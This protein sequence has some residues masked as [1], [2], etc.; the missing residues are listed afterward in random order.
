MAHALNDLAAHL[1]ALAE[2]LGVPRNVLCAGEKPETLAVQRALEVPEGSALAGALASRIAAAG[3]QKPGAS[4]PLGRIL[5]EHPDLGGSSAPHEVLGRLLTVLAALAGDSQIRFLDDGDRILLEATP[6][7]ATDAVQELLA[8][9]ASLKLSIN[10]AK[11][12]LLTRLAPADDAVVRYFVCPEKAAARL[13][14]PLMEIEGDFPDDGRKLVLLV[15]DDDVALDGDHLAVVGG[16][17]LDDWG[18]CS[19]RRPPAEAAGGA[20]GEEAQDERRVRP[21]EMAEDAVENVNW[22]DLHFERLTPLH[23]SVAPSAEGYACES[24]A[25]ARAL[26]ARLL[27]LC[28]AYSANQTRRTRESAKEKADD[29]TATFGRDD[30]LARV[31]FGTAAAGVGLPEEFLAGVARVVDMVVWAYGGRRK[32]KDRLHAFQNVVARNLRGKPET[33]TYAALVGLAEDVEREMSWFWATYWEGKLGAYFDRVA[34]VMQFVDEVRQT[35]EDQVQRLTKSLADSVLA[36]VAVVV[37]TFIAAM[38]QSPFNATLFRIGILLYVAYLFFFPGLLGL[39]SA[40]TQFRDA[41][42]TFA[43]RKKL[44]RAHLYEK[45]VATLLKPVEDGEDRFCF[46][47]ALTALIYV[48]VCCFL[49]LGAL[50]GP[51]LI[52]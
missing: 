28:L 47:F 14:R 34:Q 22:I 5:A 7:L 23:L 16:R 13:S 6:G 29:W 43:E 38:F 39:T 10:L 18:Q 42:A 19:A 25:I 33:E 41:K 40:W 31:R 4:T 1:F 46:W 26:Y 49:L 11:K 21:H 37:G 15:A 45:S 2:L 24:C 27:D 36:G 12:A 8:G 35:Y 17:F 50:V 20:G 9:D 3:A 51:L 44:F 32:D 30:S 52:E 48:A